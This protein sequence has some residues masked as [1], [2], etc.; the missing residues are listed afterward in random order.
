MAISGPCRFTFQAST[1]SF[2]VW[3]DSSPPGSPAPPDASPAQ[4]THRSWRRTPCFQNRGGVVEQHAR[5]AENQGDGGRDSGCG[6]P[7]MFE[8]TL[9]ERFKT[10][11]ADGSKRSALA[12]GVVSRLLGWSLYV[13]PADQLLIVP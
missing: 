3:T 7:L 13:P 9:K 2:P 10:L 1:R 12:G 4:L 6:G 5:R 8:L 11:S